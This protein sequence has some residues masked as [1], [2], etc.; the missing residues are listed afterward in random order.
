MIRN[1]PTDVC[2]RNLCKERQN[3]ERKPVLNLVP[4]SHKRLTLRKR[5]MCSRNIGAHVQQG[6]QST[7]DKRMGLEIGVPC[8][9]DRCQKLVS[10]N[11]AK[12]LEKESS[13]KN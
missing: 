13:N 11:I 5:G 9:Q 6:I 1:R 10:S 3:G 7:K 2:M 8:N 12:I 4:G